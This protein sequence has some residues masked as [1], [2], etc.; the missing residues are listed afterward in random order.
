MAKHLNPPYNPYTPNRK[1]PPYPLGHCFTMVKCEKCGEYY[2]PI[3]IC[4]HICKKQNSYPVKEEKR[5]EK[6]TF[7][8]KTKKRR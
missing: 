7:Q 3:C 4:E 1:N 8:R 6:D 2:E 5:N